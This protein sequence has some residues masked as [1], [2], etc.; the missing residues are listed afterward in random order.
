MSSLVATAV[1]HSADAHRGATMPDRS[2]RPMAPTLWPR[3]CASLP[4]TRYRRP[5]AA[6]AALERVPRRLVPTQVAVERRY[7][8]VPPTGVRRRGPRLHDG[9]AGAGRGPASRRSRGRGAASD[10][11]YRKQEQG[12]TVGH[13]EFLR[14]NCAQPLPGAGEL[15]RPALT[16]ERRSVGA[17]EPHPRPARPLGIADRYPGQVAG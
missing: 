1:P 13:F 5:D 9:L 10:S 11:Q 8:L 6:R 12:T 16:A 17:K 7:T 4:A 14:N 15:F 2:P 3:C